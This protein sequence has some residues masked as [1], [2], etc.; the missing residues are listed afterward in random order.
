M[1]AVVHATP[2]MDTGAVVFGAVLGWYLYF[3]MRLQRTHS[4]KDL[5][6]LA[7]AI[8]S[9]AVIKIFPDQLFG[10]YCVGLG[11]GFFGYFAVG[12]GVAVW[13]GVV[14]QFLFADADEGT[15]FL[16]GPRSPP[17]ASG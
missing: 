8:G 17:G 12:L 2:L 6:V 4:V 5:G 10:W 7:A 3:N 15:A 11:V 16:T 13:L 1:L 9:G 14:R